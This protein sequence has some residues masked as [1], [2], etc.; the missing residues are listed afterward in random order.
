MIGSLSPSFLSAWHIRLAVKPAFGF[1]LSLPFLLADSRPLND[2][3][4]F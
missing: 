1:T 2:S 4:T 3:V